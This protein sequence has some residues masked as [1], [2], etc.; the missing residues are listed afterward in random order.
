MDQLFKN[1]LN[2]VSY[3]MNLTFSHWIFKYKTK[4]IWKIG[5]ASKV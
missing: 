2:N 1:Q 4:R 3:Q 5:T